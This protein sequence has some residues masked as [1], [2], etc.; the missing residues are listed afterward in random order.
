VLY[1]HICACVCGGQRAIPGIFLNHTSCMYVCM[2]ACMY[3]CMHVCIHVCI[4]LNL[5]G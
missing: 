1:V 3:V 5:E 4:H 2:Y